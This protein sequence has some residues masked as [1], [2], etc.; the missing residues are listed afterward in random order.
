[1][2]ETLKDS[3][4]SIIGICGMAG[5][6][7]TKMVNEIAERVK[8][9]KSFDEVAIA[10]VSQ[11]PDSF[12]I[13]GELADQLGL[14]NLENDSIRER[15]KLLHQRLDNDKRILVI[16]DDFWTDLD[17]ASLGIPINTVEKD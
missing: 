6:G 10:I 16:L 3:E 14:K 2:L 5:V 12:K 1:V 8:V 17:L 11:S 7:K 4:V 9:D 15:A 13:Q